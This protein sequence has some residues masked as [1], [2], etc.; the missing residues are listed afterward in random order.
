MGSGNPNLIYKEVIYGKEGNQGE[1]V[2]RSRPV[3]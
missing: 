2:F 3:V 1:A